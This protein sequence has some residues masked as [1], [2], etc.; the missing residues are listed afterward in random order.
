MSMG[1]VKMTRAVVMMKS[2]LSIREPYSIFIKYDFRRLTV[3][4]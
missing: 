1:N 4:H 2:C 3:R